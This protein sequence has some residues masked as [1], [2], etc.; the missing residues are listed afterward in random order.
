VDSH[1]ESAREK[2]PPKA[3]KLGRIELTPDVPVNIGYV[4]G[5]RTL[6]RKSKTKT[7]T[8]GIPSD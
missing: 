7:L 2:K 3:F 1:R 6:N 5:V 8:A 4:G